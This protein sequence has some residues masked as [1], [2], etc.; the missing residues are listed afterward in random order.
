V[1]I[2]SSSDDDEPDQQSSS[3]APKTK[4]AGRNKSFKGKARAGSFQFSGIVPKRRQAAGSVETPSEPIKEEPSAE[5]LKQQIMKLVQSEQDID[6][7]QK[8]L[9]FLN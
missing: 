2:S 6:K 4:K 8:V 9:N 1:I 5:D 3:S 7:L